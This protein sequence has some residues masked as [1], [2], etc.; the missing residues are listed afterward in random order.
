M[1]SERKSCG[2]Q[3]IP[4][5]SFSSGFHALSLP[6]AGSIL[7]GQSLRSRLTLQKARFPGCPK[8]PLNQLPTTC[9][10]PGRHHTPS[11]APASGRPEAHFPHPGRGGRQTSKGGGRGRAPGTPARPGEEPGQRPGCSRRARGKAE[12]RPA[13]AKAAV[14]ALSSAEGLRRT[15][16]GRLG[17]PSAKCTVTERWRKPEFACN[18]GDECSRRRA[19][20]AR[21][22]T[23]ETGAGSPRG[24]WPRRGP[25]AARRAADA[26]GREDGG[27]LASPARF[28]RRSGCW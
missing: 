15:A 14:R 17:E 13:I 10:R 20:P 11:G 6:L 3:T 28:C 21:K 9:H 4:A 19:H 24:R 26:S 18:S 1:R 12:I 23:R 8:T 2:F 27:R 7:R 16:A 25:A 22:R 5:R